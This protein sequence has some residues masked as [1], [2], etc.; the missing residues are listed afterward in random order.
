MTRMQRN[1]VVPFF[2]VLGAGCLIAG[3]YSKDVETGCLGIFFWAAAGIVR[4]MRKAFNA[5]AGLEPLD[6][7]SLSQEELFQMKKDGHSRVVYKVCLECNT[8]NFKFI[9]ENVNRGCF[10]NCIGC[11]EI[12]K[13]PS[14]DYPIHEG[15]MAESF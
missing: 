10:E 11:G 2:I 15:E 4:S 6:T 5:L 7:G 1:A 12:M 9:P 13:F 3:I 14:P 8:M